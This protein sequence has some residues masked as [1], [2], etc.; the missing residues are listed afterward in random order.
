MCDH[1][2]KH[3]NSKDFA[4]DKTNTT[5]TTDNVYYK[6]I[7]YFIMWINYKQ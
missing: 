1:A 6:K 4:T 5:E 2:D 7:S 3:T